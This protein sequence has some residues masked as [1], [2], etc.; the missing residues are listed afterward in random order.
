LIWGFVYVI[1]NGGGLER[2]VLDLGLEHVIVRLNRIAQ[3][4]RHEVVY[5]VPLRIRDRLLRELE[6]AYRKESVRIRYYILED[7]IKKVKEGFVL[8]V[9]IP[10]IETYTSFKKSDFRKV[11]F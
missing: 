4:L 2:R 5:G 11:Y 6:E 9:D 7:I 1:F 8:D 3:V 10:V